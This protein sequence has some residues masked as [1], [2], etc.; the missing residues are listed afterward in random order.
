[1]SSRKFVFGEGEK[2]RKGENAKMGK[3]EDER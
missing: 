3:W 2:M 1:M